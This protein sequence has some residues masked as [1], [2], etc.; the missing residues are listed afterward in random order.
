LCLDLLFNVSDD[1]SNYN[2]R[3]LLEDVDESSMTAKRYD[4]SGLVDMLEMVVDD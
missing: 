3:Y 2:R 1:N 4:S